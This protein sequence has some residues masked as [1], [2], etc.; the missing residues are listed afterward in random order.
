MDTPSVVRLAN[1]IADQFS[2]RPEP[3]A[4]EAVADHVRKFWDPRMREQLMALA[5]DGHVDLQPLA[6]RAA[7]QLQ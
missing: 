4:V 6:L 5:R 3:A 1:D 7:R 2:H